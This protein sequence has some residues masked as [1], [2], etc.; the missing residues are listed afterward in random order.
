MLL[1][2]QPINRD[3]VYR[4]LPQQQYQPISQYYGTDSIVWL[5]LLIEPH[6]IFW[7][8]MTAHNKGAAP[9]YNNRIQQQETTMGTD[10]NNQW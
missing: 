7:N 8:L 1:E 10:N 9:E 2:H 4:V 3:K 6:N 5:V